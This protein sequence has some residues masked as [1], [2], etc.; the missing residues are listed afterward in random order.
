MKVTENS[1]DFISKLKAMLSVDFSR[2]PP[3]HELR[4][5]YNAGHLGT[6]KL[7]ELNI[8]EYVSLKPRL[9]HCV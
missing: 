4:N 2:L 6:W 7:T 8:R 9:L 1:Y 3:T 5:H